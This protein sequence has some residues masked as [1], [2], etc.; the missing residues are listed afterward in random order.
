LIRD[1]PQIRNIDSGSQS[2]AF[3]R[4]AFRFHSI[5]FGD[6]FNSIDPKQTSAAS[7]CCEA[8]HSPQDSD[9]VGYGSSAQRGTAPG[10]HASVTQSITLAIAAGGYAKPLYPRSRSA[11]GLEIARIWPARRA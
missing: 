8:Q 2:A 7:L 6:F 5:F 11:S 9:V 3:D 10:H 1:S 4:F